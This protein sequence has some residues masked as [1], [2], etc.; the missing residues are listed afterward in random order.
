MNNADLYHSF[1]KLFILPTMHKISWLCIIREHFKNKESL[2]A[3]ELHEHLYNSLDPTN[4]ILHVCLIHN[5]SCENCVESFLL[6]VKSKISC[7]CLREQNKRF[8]FDY[9]GRRN[10][11]P[12]FLNLENWVYIRMT[13]NCN[14]NSIFNNMVDGHKQVIRAINTQ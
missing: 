1:W 3:W 14:S 5:S 7:K 9:K 13:M 2:H 10:Q 4:L 8:S 11:S 12:V 6:C